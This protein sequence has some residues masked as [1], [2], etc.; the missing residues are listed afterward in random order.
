VKLRNTEAQKVF[1]N[2]V[3]KRSNL[4]GAFS[5]NNAAEV[6]G[7]NVLLID[8]ICDSKATIREIGSL[9]SKLGVNKIAPLVITKTI[10]GDIADDSPDFLTRGRINS[11]SPQLYPKKAANNVVE[12]EVK[13]FAKIRQ[14]YP[15]AYERWTNEEQIYQALRKWRLE[16]AE[17]YNLPAYCILSNATLD[18]IAKAKPAS[19]LALL[20]IKGLGKTTIKKYGEEIIEII[21]KLEK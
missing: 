9:M 6:A 10:G 15:R 13:P 2:S 18:N 3:L 8:D 4:K 12:E 7:K 17:E 1:Q 16:K 11:V 20:D 21:N 19:L 14:T 5:Y